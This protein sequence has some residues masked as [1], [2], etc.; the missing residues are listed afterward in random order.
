MHPGAIAALLLALSFTL[1][2]IYTVKRSGHRMQPDYILDKYVASMHGTE[3]CGEPSQ[4]QRA[5]FDEKYIG[6]RRRAAKSIGKDHPDYNEQQ[7]E[8]AVVALETAARDSAANMVQT[9]GCEAKD[10]RKLLRSF[11]MRAR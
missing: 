5:A 4:Q 7:I 1:F 6:V 8:A 11:E 9:S 10:V 2:E 3:L